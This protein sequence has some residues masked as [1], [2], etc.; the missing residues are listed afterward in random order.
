MNVRDVQRDPLQVSRRLIYLNRLIG[1]NIVASSTQ[2]PRPAPWWRFLVYVVY[3]II[4]TLWILHEVDP[5]YIGELN[6]ALESKLRTVTWKVDE[7]VNY[8]FDNV[9]TSRDVAQFIMRGLVPEFVVGNEFGEKFSLMT[10]N[11]AIPNEDVC[12]DSAA[13]YFTIRKMGTKATQD[14]LNKTV[15][16]RFSALY[17][18]VWKQMGIGDGEPITESE[19][20][21]ATE[22]T[23]TWQGRSFTAKE[24]TS[25]QSLPGSKMGLQYKGG[26]LQPINDST[27]LP[28]G[29]RVTVTWKHQT[30]P[31]NY[32][33]D[34]GACSYCY[35]LGGEGGYVAMLLL[36]V[37]EIRQARLD[38]SYNSGI[39]GSDHY[40]LHKH[41]VD[42]QF[43]YLLDDESEPFAD[44]AIGICQPVRIT[45]IIRA[46]D[47]AGA[48]FFTPEIS[49]AAVSFQLYNANLQTLT[50]VSMSFN[51]N[52]A[53]IIVSSNMKL[54][55]VRLVLANPFVLLT[56]FCIGTVYY[57]LELFV[58]KA[59]KFRTGCKILKDGWTYIGALSIGCSI[60]A[61][62]IKLVYG[63][64][65]DEFNAASKKKTPRVDEIQ[66]F[67]STC[68]TFATVGSIAILSMYFRMVEILAQT[69]PRVKLLEKT[70]R[71]A[72]KSMFKYLSYMII[73]MLGFVAFSAL[74][75]AP[76][77]NKF[78][79]IPSSTISCFQMLFLSTQPYDSV[80]TATL[81][82]PFLFV[83][84]MFAIISVQ[85]F[86]AIINYSY[87]RTCEDMEPIFLKLM[88]DK[89][90]RESHR[91][92]SR[93]PVIIFLHKCLKQLLEF[94]M[95]L[96]NSDE[97]DEA[98]ENKL[99]EQKQD[100]LTPAEREQ[101]DKFKKQ[102][103]TNM[104]QDSVAAIFFY[105]LFVIS[106]T[107][108]LYSNLDVETN[109]RTRHAITSTMRDTRITDG[110]TSFTEQGLEERFW[111][112]G[113]SQAITIFDV[114]HWMTRGLPFVIDGHASDKLEFPSAFDFFGGQQNYCMKHWN[115][116]LKLP[117]RGSPSLKMVRV[118][119]RFQKRAPN[120]GLPLADKGTEGR[121]HFEGGPL[122]S[123][124]S[125]PATHQSPKK[126]PST[127]H[128]DTEIQFDV[129][130]NG[131]KFCQRDPNG[132]YHNRGGIVCLLDA[133]LA[134]MT[135]QLLTMYQ[136]GFYSKRTSSIIVEFTTFNANTQI[137]AYVRISFHLHP[138]GLVE[139]DMYVYPQKL[140]TL[141][142]W[143][144][145]DDVG[146]KIGNVFKT[147]FQW[148]LIWGILYIILVV[149]LFLAMIQELRLDMDSKKINSYQGKLTSLIEY[150]THD[151]YHMVDVISFSISTVGIV[152][153]MAWL[154]QMGWLNGEAENFSS[155]TTYSEDLSAS[156]L[157][158]TQFSSINMVLI[159]WR[160]LKYLRGV[161]HMKNLNMTFWK[162]MTDIT[163]FC[164]MLAMF[165]MGF[166]LFAH[167]NFGYRMK[168]LNSVGSAFM[169]CFMCLIGEF[170]FWELYD[171]S[172]WR[173][174]F[175]FFP[176]LFLFNLFFLNV[177]FAIMDK[178]YVNK[179][180]PT[181]NW[182]LMLKPVFGRI[183]R[184]FEWDEDMNMEE[185]PQ[186]RQEKKGP[187]S[188]ADRVKD[189]A[190]KI[191]N[192]Q[193]LSYESGT[194]G[195]ARKARGLHDAIDKDEKVEEA[196]RW[197]R[198]EAKEFVDMFR[199]LLIEKEDSHN[200]DN[201]INNKAR[202][203]IEKEREESKEAMEEAERNKKY[204]IHVH[205]LMAQQDQ[206]T[207]AR[208]IIRLES[209]IESVL[210]KKRLVLADLY[211]LIAESEKMR[212]SDDELGVMQ[213]QHYVEP[214]KKL[215]PPNQKQSQSVT[216]GSQFSDW[217][218]EP[219]A[220][221]QD[222][223][224]ANTQT[225]QPEPEP[226]ALAPLPEAL[227][228]PSPSA[229]DKPFVKK[230]NAELI[231]D[232]KELD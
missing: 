73:V 41:L 76:Y 197:S 175:F 26:K 60:A 216:V 219:G 38:R 61:V 205:E 65:L 111:S 133:D 135:G 162:A 208:Y 115:C 72:L 69:P 212:Y 45:N 5:A 121:Q 103:A 221:M 164:V 57:F 49:S 178:N 2:I 102:D 226:K 152:L 171:V 187:P 17:P 85:M 54:N 68:S 66:G 192:L 169:Y 215:A 29:T 180:V 144:A 105:A 117:Q 186:K 222:I 106:Y 163:W 100:D 89:K 167:I 195:V 143:E 46:A 142:G 177:F 202:R 123:T 201:F 31:K 170:D 97:K 48:G 155:F 179:E 104:R 53:G 161:P 110:H 228:L 131:E 83:F 227:A 80:R 122:Y 220:A 140:I 70:L 199:S 224:A 58:Y 82:L 132:G 181:V 141:Y 174:F 62:L 107:M 200:E 172:P 160:F 15:T 137:M 23:F 231:E 193:E 198:V 150:F 139:R 109:G 229:D 35:G 96:K 18:R 84:F 42:D 99:K 21:S 28:H 148:R 194:G 213:D 116:L 63:A 151:V 136:Q 52:A 157:L 165:F 78:I 146:K 209:K 101:L 33:N 51:F 14:D 149:V 91:K 88:R 37:D 176:Y 6:Y 93:N 189:T 90:I 3:V 86:N 12:N 185:D 191:R 118:T 184:C 50:D 153:F 71:S 158:Y 79:D 232:L 87:N 127:K 188:R 211:H 81:A 129:T 39:A 138:S 13:I 124:L 36:R 190:E 218:E 1:D 30:P 125:G 27:T 77:S 74:H 43:L 56:I 9:T 44:P 203:K 114:A 40:K 112:R 67:A 59:Y 75:F 47:M 166:V 92:A 168:S 8:H 119:Q 32:K 173:A 183:C 55:S 22:G 10:Y 230:T 225:L 120:N 95:K 147:A 16:D 25:N 204:A 64:Q 126:K 182:K 145:S 94:C 4:A 108:F 223:D 159:S 20:K 19:Q 214:E 11:R 130:F 210:K 206:E 98:A 154:V 196:L 7:G 113:V 207:L 156:A 134:N 128:E 34:K 217:E 24:L